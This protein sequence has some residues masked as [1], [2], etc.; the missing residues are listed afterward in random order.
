MPTKTGVEGAAKAPVDEEV[1]E[2]GAESAE[3]VEETRAVRGQL[4][5]INHWKTVSRMTWRISG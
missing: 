2:E 1:A 5:T 4:H 3:E